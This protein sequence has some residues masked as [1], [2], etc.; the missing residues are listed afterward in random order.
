MNDSSMALTSNEKLGLVTIIIPALNE[1]ESIGSTLRELVPECD[2]NGWHIIVVDDG[3]SDSTAQIVASEWN[4]QVELLRHKVRRGYGAA[5]K[6]GIAR[7]TTDYA[8]TFDADGQHD[9]ADLARLLEAALA[10]D[11]DLV[12]GDRGP[13]ASGWYRRLGKWIIRSIAHLLLPIHVRDLNSGIK[14][15]RAELGQHYSAFL[16]DALAFSDVLTLAF[17]SDHRVVIEIPVSIRDRSGGKSTITT[18][19]A[20]DTVIEIVN[21]ITLFNPMRIFIPLS[22][23]GIFA[24]IA[25]GTPIVLTGRGVSVG[26]MLAIVTGVILFALGLLAE[27]LSAI[28]KGRSPDETVVD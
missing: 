16:P 2:R 19:T 23:A 12:I 4:E 11:A 20:L 5:I 14:L 13:N 25:W 17:I 27:Q 8:V 9:P 7:T 21:I 28:R 15:F 18:M 24:G 1:E 22:A 6:T 26:A 10:G 3:S